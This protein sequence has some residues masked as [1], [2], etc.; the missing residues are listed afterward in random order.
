MD[1]MTQEANDSIVVEIFDQ[2]Y[3]LCGSDPDYIRK[4]AEHVDSKMH[5]IAGETHTAD[6]EQLAVLAA[7]RIAAEYDLLKRKLDG[8]V[9]DSSMSNHGSEWNEWKEK[10]PEGEER[11]TSGEEVR[12]MTEED[13]QRTRERRERHHTKR[14]YE[15]QLLAIVNDESLPAKERHEA[16]FALGRSRGYDPAPG[17]EIA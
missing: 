12:L 3:N 15:K 6:S 16:L 7:V 13:R 4:L 5:A 9:S 2:E 8:G 1:H 10:M 11:E 17:Q 14:W